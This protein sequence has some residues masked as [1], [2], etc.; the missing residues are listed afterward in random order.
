MGSD[1][2]EFDCQ[3]EKWDTSSVRLTQLET[4]TEKISAQFACMS[5]TSVEV[6]DNSRK[7]PLTSHWST[8]PNRLVSVGG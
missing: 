8:T 5:G 7:T 1:Y 4:Y 3:N 2:E 6:E